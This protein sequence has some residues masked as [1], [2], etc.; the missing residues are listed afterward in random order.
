MAR[1]EKS[2]Y[3]MYKSWTPLIQSIPDEAAGKLLK[4][5]TAFQNGDDVEIDEPM[6]NAV[7][8]MMKQTF[9]IDDEKYRETCEKRREAGKKGGRPSGSATETK[10]NPTKPNETNWFYE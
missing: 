6:I 5:I 7:F 3:V 8:Q 9:I 2:G 4:A 10:P 1:S